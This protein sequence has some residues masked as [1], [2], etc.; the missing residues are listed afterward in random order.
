MWCR[1]SHSTVWTEIWKCFQTVS[2]KK[3]SMDNCCK[4]FFLVQ[5]KSLMYSRQ[6]A[7]QCDCYSL[8]QV[9]TEEAELRLCHVSPDSCV[10]WILGRFTYRCTVQLQESYDWMKNKNALWLPWR[11]LTRKRDRERDLLRERFI[12]Y[13]QLERP[14]EGEFISL[15]WSSCTLHIIT[16]RSKTIVT[17][18]KKLTR[19]EDRERL[20]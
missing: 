16:H 8:S 13:R 2:G 4:R 9:S 19:K 6:C 5:I 20:V 12:D 11:N 7:V 18:M 15:S 1:L 14:V 17:A 3:I 10:S